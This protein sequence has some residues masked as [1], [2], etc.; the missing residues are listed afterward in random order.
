MIDALL[1]SVRDEVIAAGFGWDSRTCDIMADGHPP[2]R[3]V[4][5]F[6]AVHQESERGDMMN[7]LNEYYDFTLTLTKALAGTPFDRAGTQLLANTKARTLAKETG[8]NA[9]AQQ[10]KTFLHMN[11]FVI[12]RANTLLTEMMEADQFVNG[13]CEP[14]H[15]DDTTLP[16]PVGGEWFSADPNQKNSGIT[17]EIRFRGARRLQ[18]IA[19]YS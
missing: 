2:P 15:W 18:P 4:D 6:L 7:A 11:W 5:W 1:F 9:R 19:T 17:C 8:F 16:K 14:A 12:G 13:F 3:A 10:L